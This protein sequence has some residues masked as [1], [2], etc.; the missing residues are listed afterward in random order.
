MALV[1]GI[2]RT[3]LGAGLN[4]IKAPAN[5]F[6]RLGG[7]SR[8]ATSLRTALDNADASVRGAAGTVLGDDELKEDARTRR[9]A[10]GEARRK[11]EQ[12]RRKREQAEKQAES[13]AKTR[14]Q[15]ARKKAAKKKEEAEKG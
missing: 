3:A 13:R 14:K 5:L 4:V 2:S 8:V 12:A 7:S 9:E 6:L 11:R 10:E 15:S 1:R